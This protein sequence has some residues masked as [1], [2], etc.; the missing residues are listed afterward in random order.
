MR[1]KKNFYKALSL[2]LVFALALTLLPAFQLPAAAASNSAPTVANTS[3]AFPTIAEDVA[4]SSNTGITVSSL[5]NLAG[6]SDADHNML[7]IAVTSVDDSNGIWELEYNG[8][9]QLTRYKTVTT[10][11]DSNVYLVPNVCSIRFKPGADF[12]GQA[13]FTF[14][15]WDETSGTADNNDGSAVIDASGSNNG[16]STAFS[17]GTVTASITVSAVND[18]PEIHLSGLNNALSFDGSNDYV[19]VPDLGLNN[20]SFT[21]EGWIYARSANT[22]SRFFDFGSGYGENNGHNLI[23][24]FDGTTGKLKFEMWKGNTRDA[25]SLRAI[26]AN[27]QFPLNQWVYV[28]AVFNSATQMGYLYY[29]D[30]KLQGTMLGCADSTA[31]RD[32]SYFGRSNWADDLYFNGKMCN[33]A[34]WKEARTADEINSDKNTSFCGTE[35]NLVL[36]YPL[37]DAAGSTTVQSTTGSNTGSLMNYASV[38]GAETS[39]ANNAMIVNDNAFDYQ[40]SGPAGKNITADRMYIKDVDA[41]AAGVTLAL[42]ASRGTLAMNPTNGVAISGNGTAS[43]TASGTVDDLNSALKTL[44]YLSSTACTD[45]ITATVNDG[46]HT[47]SGGLKSTS[48]IIDVTVNAAPDSGTTPTI[49]I[50]PP[51]SV[52]VALGHEADFSVTVTGPTNGGSYTCQWQKSTDGGSTWSDISGA[53]SETYSIANTTTGEDGNQYRCYVYDA[54]DNTSATSDKAILTVTYPILKMANVTPAIGA[55]GIAVDTSLTLTFNEDI[56]AGAGS[57]HVVGPSGNDIYTISVNGN[58]YVA[59]DHTAHTVTVTLPGNLNYITKYHIL[60]DAG[61]FVDQYGGAYAGLSDSSAWNFTMTA[62]PPDLTPPTLTDETPANGSTGIPVN[63]QLTM[64]FSENILAVTGNITVKKVSDDSTVQTISV[65]GSNVSVNNN[66]VSVTLPDSLDYSTQ[67]YVLIDSG[68]FTDTSGNPYAGLSDKTAWSFT[69]TAAPAHTVT[70]YWNYTGAPEPYTTQTVV[71]GSKTAAPEVPVRSGYIFNGWYTDSNCTSTWNFSHDAIYGSTALYV[72]WQSTAKYTVTYDGNGASSGSVPKD[73]TAYSSGDTV[74]VKGNTGSLAQVGYT[75]AGWSNGTTTYTAG[76]TFTITG[77]ANLTAVWTLNPAAYT[78]TYSSNYNGGG[79]YATQTGVTNGA[80]L[81]TPSTT[82]VRT[83]YTFIG[84]Y[85]DE[86]CVNAWNFSLDTVTGNTTLYGKWSE[87]TYQVI[88]T[89]DDDTSTPVAGATVKVMQGNLQFGNTV[90]TD[91]NGDFTVSGVPNGDYNIVVTK[92]VQVVTVY[93]TVNNSDYI[94]SGQIILPSGN[95]N[96][97]LVVLGSDTPN[98]VVDGLNDIF[99]D[100]SIYTSSDS[101]AVTSGGTVEIELTV[102]KNDNS[103]NKS[104]VEAAVI[105]D[106]YTVGTIFDVDM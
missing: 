106:G 44:T 50:Q 47:G 73:N 86:A 42:T 13:F 71:D 74:A 5:L 51:S 27:S 23:V 53:N 61:T 29:N 95:K 54:T 83:G 94:C 58:S 32:K 18:A 46:G 57:I 67:Y 105:T 90:Q 24:Y 6:A 11:S 56:N 70:Y 93:I 89:V 3:V 43:L 25:N 99:Q 92:N 37:N 38:S 35:P 12:N 7:S 100:S 16:G 63:T 82:P 28:A 34:V 81:T 26:V 97:R 102:Q 85:K 80:A 15:V 21:V 10:V 65:A 66:T 40:I 76:Q 72:G 8:W 87:S 55:T 33:I 19:S 22:F 96:S 60:I 17:A 84:W 69:T 1:M 68:A 79:T 45:T 52:T 75:F 48:E 39:A 9:N 30:I 88:G 77:D 62:A 59:I 104:V 31:H 64:A 49:I 36:Y 2:F 14:R 98:V 4:D 103:E 41:G 20:G 78:V 101:N 91:I